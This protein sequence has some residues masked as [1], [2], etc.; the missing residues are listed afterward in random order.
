MEMPRG[1]SR[2]DLQDSAGQPKP[3]GG[4][5]S[6]NGALSTNE[7]RGVGA[8][9]PAPGTLPSRAVGAGN[10]RDNPRPPRS[11]LLYHVLYKIFSASFR[12]SA[13]IKRFLAPGARGAAA[14]PAYLAPRRLPG[15]KRWGQPGP[16]LGD[17]ALSRRFMNDTITNVPSPRQRDTATESQRA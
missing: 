15:E 1:C 2:R 7:F 9:R 14:A 8:A 3:S 13:S 6:P 10:N 17:V 4:E 5:A 12:M 11:L 16:L